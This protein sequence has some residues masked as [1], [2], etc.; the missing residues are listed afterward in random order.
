MLID[1]LSRHRRIIFLSCLVIIGLAIWITATSE[2]FVSEFIIKFLVTWSPVFS[3]VA[4]VIL[5]I[6]TF[7]EI[8][9]SRRVRSISRKERILNS[10]YNW[11]F[12]VKA[13]TTLL[14]IRDGRT[15]DRTNTAAKLTTLLAQGNA[16]SSED[17]DLGI[18]LQQARTKALTCFRQSI[19]ALMNGNDIETL[20]SVMGEVSNS[21]TK[22]MVLVS[23]EHSKI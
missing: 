14:D 19:D 9:E 23:L 1:W 21:L 8:K 3:T 13:S 16:L 22:I 7:S 20:T 6:A 18:E 12:A 17:A 15:I 2:Y 4:V 5:A 11:A 10:L